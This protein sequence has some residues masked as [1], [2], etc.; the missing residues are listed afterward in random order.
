MVSIFDR[1]QYNNSV[2]KDMRD[3]IYVQLLVSQQA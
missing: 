3:D 2:K 1:P